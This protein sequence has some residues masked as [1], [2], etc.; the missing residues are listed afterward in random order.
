MLCYDVWYFA[1]ATWFDHFFSLLSD[2]QLF[3]HV[4]RELKVEIAFNSKWH[5]ISNEEW[6]LLIFA[7]QSKRRKRII[8]LRWCCCCCSIIYLFHDVTF[9][10][11]LRELRYFARSIAC[12]TVMWFLV[13]ELCMSKRDS[14]CHFKLL[15]S[16][17]SMC[18]FLFFSQVLSRKNFSNSAFIFLFGSKSAEKKNWVCMC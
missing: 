1:M 7:H 8:F 10:F 15:F 4:R 17:R 16:A 5:R 3:A 13:H 18:F 6:A 11:H 9:V 12:Q 14:K 2:S